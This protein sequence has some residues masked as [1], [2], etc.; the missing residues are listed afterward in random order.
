MLPG[1]DKVAPTPTPVSSPPMAMPSPVTN[2]LKQATSAAALDSAGGASSFPAYVLADFDAEIEGVE[3]SVRKDDFLTVQVGY[4]D[5]PPP[6]GWCMCSIRRPDG[7][8]ENG[9]VPWYFLVSAV[10]AELQA[11][12]EE[13]VEQMPIDV[14]AADVSNEPGEYLEITVMRGPTGALGIDVDDAN[15]IRRVS[16]AAA[17]AAIALGGPHQL[18]EGDLIVSVD[19]E[20]L[21]SKS[22][23]DAMEPAASSYLFGIFRRQLDAETRAK[24]S[25]G[26]M[27]TMR[28]QAY[29]MLYTL[30]FI[31]SLCLR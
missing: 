2:T 3:L 6:E 12:I 8:I 26:I 21:G 20:T 17:S 22:L 31:L 4:N 11:T 15:L 14:S 28:L 7:A 30:Y 16:P 19:G 27:S 18:Q 10:H 1:E 25:E 13:Q 24:Y 23:L 29:F 9:L 5:S